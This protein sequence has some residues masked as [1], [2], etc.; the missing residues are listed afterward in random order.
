MG[1]GNRDI[2][3]LSDTFASASDDI[4]D[5]LAPFLDVATSFELWPFTSVEEVYEFAY[6]AFFVVRT[7]T[8]RIEHDGVH[9][10]CYESAGLDNQDADVEL[11]NFFGQRLGHALVIC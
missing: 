4:K 1:K 6:I 11:S 3:L 2:I 10:V 5:R 7:H 8:L 9:H